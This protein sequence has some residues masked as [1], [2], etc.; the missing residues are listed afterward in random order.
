MEIDMHISK[1]MIAVAALA[2]GPAMATTAAANIGIASGA[3]ASKG[4]LKLAL[5]NRCTG[6]LAEYTDSTSNVSTYVCATG[7]FS[8]PPNATDYSSSTP[9]NF[10]GTAIAELRLNVNGGAFTAVCILAG[11]P[12]GTKCPAPDLYVD[13][14]AATPNSSAALAAVP[15]GAITVGGLM[16]LEPAGFLSTVRAGVA[17]PGSVVTAGFAQTFGVAVSDALYQALFVDQYNNGQLPAACT[18]SLTAQPECVP[19]LGKAQMASIMSNNTGSLAYTN[20]VGFL[21]Q[22]AAQKT[23]LNGT[24]LTYA[25]RVDTSGTQA[26]A[27]QYFLGSVCDSAPIPVV[28]ENGSAGAITVT[29]LPTT[30]GVRTALNTAG[31]YA[32]GIMSGENNQ[33]G[34]TWKWV[35]VGGMQMT[36]NAAPGVGSV[37]NTASALDGRYDYWFLSRIAQP[38]ATGTAATFWTS[39]KAGFANVP[40]GNTKGLFKTSET[41]YTKGSSN[42]CLPVTSN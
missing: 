24:N 41:A 8:T 9:V 31:S 27:Q 21:M 16:D 26:S 28:T 13:P 40:V 6:T 33:T 42:S 3:S 4:N 35:R 14:A 18:A 12:A 36:E 10:T 19:V 5:A 38:A 29:A 15:S 30:G 20:G 17:N 25:R 1:I 23:A 22:T 32:I 2:A 34:Q 11:W 37:T 7:T 39:V